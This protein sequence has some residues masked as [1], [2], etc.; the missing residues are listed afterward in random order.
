MLR[1]AVSSVCTQSLPDFELIVVDDGSVEPCGGLP[2]DPRIRIIRN[3]SS[4]GVAQARN[5]G[6]QAAKGRYISFLDDDDEYLRSFLQHTYSTLRHSPT[7]VGVSWCGVKFIDYPL[8]PEAAV[9]TITFAEHKNRQSLLRDFLSIG[10]GFGVTIKADCLT[11]VGP[12]NGALKVCSDSDMFFRILVKGF[13]PIAVPGVHVVRH[14]HR[15]ARLTS[16]NWDQER[17]RI[18]EDWIFAQYSGFLDENPILRNNLL[19]YIDS[20]KKG[21]GERL[22]Q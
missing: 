18:W 22:T 19:G 1:R 9:R 21:L 20:L 13:T 8:E 2:C 4:L 15:E 5:A 17:I 6:I 14:N 11:R 10:T 3:P 16:V 12:F 7:K